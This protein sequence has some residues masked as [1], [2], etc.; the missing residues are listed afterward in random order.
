MTNRPIPRL[1]LIGPLDAVSLPRYVE[2]AVQAVSAGCDAVH[3]RLPGASGGDVVQLARL[4]RDAVD[5]P[6]IV[7]DR[8]DVAKL[9]SAEALQLGER[10]LS[11]QDARSVLGT[12]MLIGR[13]VHDLT[14][15]IAA[16]RAGAD[17]LMAGNVF[18]TASKRGQ[19]GRG[20]G[21]F[22]ELCAIVQI[23]VI[24]IGGVQ[25]HH[26]A[27]LTQAGAHGVAVGR[28]IL[29]AESPRAATAAL[30]SELERSFSC[31]HASS[32]R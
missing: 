6:L 24:A 7:N 20:L 15:A 21:W 25:A 27:E 4:L 28:E 10:S 9:T 31:S 19:P 17:Y 26:V 32:T 29:L 1:Q 5:A 18:E 22:A 13:S 2:V 14:G 12:A 11:V 3:V 23:P 8:A 30:R 16:E